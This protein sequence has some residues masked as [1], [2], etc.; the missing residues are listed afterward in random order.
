MTAALVTSLRLQVLC[1]HRGKEVAGP[2]HLSRVCPGLGPRSQSLG[3][4]SRIPERQ[5]I[6]ERPGAAGGGQRGRPVLPELSEWFTGSGWA[7]VL[8]TQSSRE[9][10]SSSENR[11]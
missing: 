5:G 7:S 3:E 8:N 2:T 1:P 4:Q 9:S 6:P 11:R 10:V